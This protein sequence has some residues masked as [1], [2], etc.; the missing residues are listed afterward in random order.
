MVKKY[1]QKEGLDYNDTFS[2]VAKMITVRTV[3]NI[4]ASHNWPLFQMDV[5]NSFL[6][7]DL[8]EEVY[9]DMPLRFSQA[10]RE[11]KN[12]QVT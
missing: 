7:D 12:L 4:A 3:I 5:S 9:M 10:R 11:K 2:H 1:T 8:H 6:Q